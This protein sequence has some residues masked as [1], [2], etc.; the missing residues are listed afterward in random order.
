MWFTVKIY[1]TDVVWQCDM[2]KKP[3]DEGWA[4]D[5]V[6]PSDVEWAK[7]NNFFREHPEALDI[8]EVIETTRQG[9]IV[10]SSSN[11]AEAAVALFTSLLKLEPTTNWREVYGQVSIEELLEDAR[12]VGIPT[13]WEVPEG[14]TVMG[15]SLI[16]VR[17]RRLFLVIASGD[18]QGLVV[19]SQPSLALLIKEKGIL[20]LG[21]RG[22]DTDNNRVEIMER[23]RYDGDIVRLDFWNVRPKLN[24]MMIL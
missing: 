13:L 18:L 21:Y 6:L 16:P 1:I 17:L 9:L 24:V 10:I 23:A 22:S 14:I 7:Y 20:Y 3:R 2:V 5:R 19:F 4:G 8:K 15:H 11:K 12:L